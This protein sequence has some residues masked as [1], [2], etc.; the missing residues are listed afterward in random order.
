MRRRGSKGQSLVETTLILA[1]FMGLILGM[2]DVGQML[3]VR[4]ALA[5]RTQEAARWGALNSYDP[6]AIRSLV[7]YGSANP[8]ER[9]TAFAGLKESEVVVG[10]PGCPGVECRVSVAIPGRGIQSVEPVEGF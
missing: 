5:E 1:S 3:F 2:V 4:Q 8:P 9:A 6:E 10:N 7:L